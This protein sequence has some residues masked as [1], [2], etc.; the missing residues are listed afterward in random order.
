MGFLSDAY[1]K[2][3]FNLQEHG[4]E[5]SLVVGVVSIVVGTVLVA[6]AAIKS[7][8]TLD[9]AKKKID[10]IN[11]TVND[12]EEKQKEEIKEVRKEAA[13][14]IIKDFAVPVVVELAGLA[15]ICGGTYKGMAR[16]CAGIATAY[17]TLSTTHEN[18]RSRVIEELGEEKDR[19]FMYGT[20]EEEDIHVKEDGEEEVVKKTVIN[21]PDPTSYDR[22]YD[23]TNFNWRDIPGFNRMFLETQERAAQ[24]K[25]IARGHITLNDVYDML[26]FPRTEVGYSVGWLRDDVNKVDF[27][28]FTANDM[29]H[30]RFLNGLEDNVWLH[31]NPVPL[32]GR[33]DKV[34]SAFDE[35]FRR[36]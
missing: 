18:Y 28:I 31:F 9:D 7:S 3:K 29:D 20:H 36:S 8:E 11:K 35:D 2:A 25:V 4:P 23:E 21:K 16:R 17:A 10:D 32:H 6:R 34:K 26:G 33:I 22:Y 5:I 19:A 1:S 15:A 27:G 12:D 24:D 30:Y 13:V 14:K